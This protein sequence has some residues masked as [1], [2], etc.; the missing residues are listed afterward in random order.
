MKKYTLIDTYSGDEINSYHSNLDSNY[1]SNLDNFSMKTTNTSDV[2]EYLKT[3][4]DNVGKINAV[5]DGIDDDIIQ[6]YLRG[7]K[8]KNINK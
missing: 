8:L 3:N 5:L 7:K 6:N 2:R 4:K 1:K